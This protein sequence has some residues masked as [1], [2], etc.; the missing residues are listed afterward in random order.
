MS[1]KDCRLMPECGDCAECPNVED[2]GAA[3]FLIEQSRLRK[4]AQR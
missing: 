4:E 3:D 2:Y 1:C